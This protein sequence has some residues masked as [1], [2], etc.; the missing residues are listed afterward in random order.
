MSHKL[1][2][3]GAMPARSMRQWCHIMDKLAFGKGLADVVR[4]ISPQWGANVDSVLSHIPGQ[5][6]DIVMGIAAVA[7]H[8]AT[9]WKEFALPQSAASWA[10][11]VEQQIRNG[12]GSAHR[13]I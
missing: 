12:A 4:N 10:A 13:L 5:D 3:L 11:C 9:V 2:A 7:S 1:N 6:A 8:G